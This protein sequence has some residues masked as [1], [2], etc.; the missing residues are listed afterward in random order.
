MT[1]PYALDVSHSST[2][3][4]LK[5]L[6]R[7]RGSVWKA[8]LPQLCFWTIAYIV[9]GVFYRYF[10]PDDAQIVFEKLARYLNKGIDA[11]IPLTFMLGFFVTFVVGR[12]SQILNGIGWIDNAAMAFAT[13]IQGAD[14][15]TKLLRRTLIRYMVLNQTLVLRDISMQVRKRFATF[16]I[17]VASGIATKAEMAELTGVKDDYA[18]YWV[19]LQWC[20]QHLTKAR[21]TGKIPSDHL[22]GKITGEIQ[23]FQHGLHLLLK[24][25]W[26]PVP[27]VYPQVVLLSVRLYFTICLISRQFLRGDNFDPWLPVVT[28]VQFVVYTGWTK[29]AEMLLN[30]LGDD[31]DDLECNYVIDKNLTSGLT[32][33][34]RGSQQPPTMEKDIFWN[35]KRVVPLYTKKASKRHVHELVGSAAKVDLMKNVQQCT[36]Y[37]HRNMLAQLSDYEKQTMTRIVAI[38]SSP[39]NNS[40]IVEVEKQKLIP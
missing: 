8:V 32:L 29:V 19:P 17:V 38:G 36:L 5:L 22:L 4:L 24:Y 13:F 6:G 7:W 16:D 40:I 27:L 10:L 20:Y 31:D 12:W 1:V 26:V 9:V 18:R 15:E 28:I 3:S 25:D 14:E 33:V 37:P 23:N 34:D 39:A 2:K 21:E 11:Y 30:P 35:D